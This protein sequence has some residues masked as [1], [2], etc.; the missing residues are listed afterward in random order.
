MILV[1][2]MGMKLINNK[3]PMAI[4][5]KMLRLLIAGAL[6]IFLS[7]CASTVVKKPDEKKTVKQDSCT[8]TSLGIK[9]NTSSQKSSAIQIKCQPWGDIEVTEKYGVDPEIREQFDKAIILLSEENYP[10]AIMLLKAVSGRTSKFS[11]PH[12][13]LGIV[14]ARTD[15]MKKAEES[16]K[17]ALDINSRHPVAINELGLVYRKTGR[18]QEAREL[19]E[20]LLSM[21]PEFMP[22][23]KNLGVLC[24]IYMQDLSC[25]YDQYQVYLKNIPDDEKVKIWVADVKN[26]M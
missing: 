16:L 15:E 14:Y 4:Q 25:A 21:Y 6:I 9:G 13:N 7:A 17:K 11:A 5:M 24:D 3:E 8:G 26:R 22:A 20:S 1:K 2:N 12:I 10:E 19:Y 18:Y 23:R